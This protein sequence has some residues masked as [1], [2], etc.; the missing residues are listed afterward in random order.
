MY[1]SFYNDG[2]LTITI[3]NSIDSVSDSGT[4]T[5]SDNGELCSEMMPNGVNWN[6]SWITSNSMILSHSNLGTETEEGNYFYQLQFDAV[7]SEKK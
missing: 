5:L 1:Y 4:W 2:T 7:S 3:V 6:V